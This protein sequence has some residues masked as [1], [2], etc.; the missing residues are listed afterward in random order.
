[1][2]RPNHLEQVKKRVAESSAGD[3]F[4]PSDFFDI[5]EAVKINKCLNRMVEGGLL[6]R[7]MRGIYMKPRYSALLNKDVPPKVD[8]I[9]KAIARNYGWT[10]AQ[11]GDTALNLL[12]LTTQVPAVWVYIS[13]GPYKSYEFDGMTIKFKHTDNKNELTNIS[14]KA[15]LVVQAFKTIGRE[16]VTGRD[17]QKIARVLTDKEKLQ[18]LNESKRVTGWVYEMIKSLNKEAKNG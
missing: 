3:I 16:N 4:I 13:D 7:I 17:L 2:S 15:A 18:I 11:F 12:G 9:A 6:R 5:A 10:I 8:S 1:M 14:Y